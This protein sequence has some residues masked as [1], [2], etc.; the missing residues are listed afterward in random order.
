MENS[1]EERVISLKS[2]SSPPAGHDAV[3]TVVMEPPQ[4]T[5]PTPQP[6]DSEERVDEGVGNLD[7]RSFNALLSR[8]SIKDA[9]SRFHVKVKFP[10][11]IS[12]MVLCKSDMLVSELL[13]KSIELLKVDACFYA[14]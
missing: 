9:H 3:E 2:N 7:F 14:F 11:N 5:P 8:E 1:G 4:S 6:D 13:D 10:Q 12:L